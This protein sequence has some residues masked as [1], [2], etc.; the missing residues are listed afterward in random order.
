VKISKKKLAFKII[1]SVAFF[2][3][4]ISFVQGNELM[5]MFSRINW[6]FLFLS[7]LISPV[8][9]VVSCLKWKMILDVG[10]KKVPFSTLFRIYLIGYFFSNMLPSTVGGDVVRSYYSGKIIQDQPFSAIAI[11]IERFSGILF[12]FFLVFLAPVLKP[13]LYKNPYIF[14]PIACSLALIVVTV[15]IWK[16]E[17]PFALPNALFKYFISILNKGLSVINYKRADELIDTINTQYEK[18]ISKLEKLNERLNTAVKTI[19]KDK[20]LFLQL[21]LITVLFYF[22][23]WVNVSFALSAFGV[24]HQFLY[25]CALVPI[26]MFVAHIPV[27]LLGNLGFFESV[28]VF[29][30]LLIDIPGVESLA[31]GLLLRMKMLLIG[32]VGFF[33]YLVYKHETGDDAKQLDKPD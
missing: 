20:K 29:Y 30:L 17:N 10:E 33:I 2:S 1:I 19:Q 25:I 5:R 27:T 4:L 31:M 14:I 13:S 12:L 7:L 6:F 21:T 9:I 15:W 32:V 26:I 22:L 3:I 28:F 16:V 8:M 11:F 23:T 24:E 18:L